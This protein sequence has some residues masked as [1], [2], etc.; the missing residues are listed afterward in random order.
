MKAK[1]FQLVSSSVVLGLMAGAVGFQW[2]QLRDWDQVDSEDES[3]VYSLVGDWSGETMAVSLPGSSMGPVFQPAQPGEREKMEDT[4]TVL[5]K[6]WSVIGELKAENQD[7]REQVKE[8]NRELIEIQFRIDTLGL[9][10]RPMMIKTAPAQP[11]KTDMNPLL[12]PKPKRLN[13]LLPP[14]PKR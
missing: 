14:K 8:S 2:Y 13:P 9:D 3:A 6:M 1:L 4:V 12:P 5:N 10:F 7:L 11:L